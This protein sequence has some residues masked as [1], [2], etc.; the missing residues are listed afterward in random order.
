MLGQASSNLRNLGRLH[1]AAEPM[2][3][4]LERRVATEHWHNAAIVAANLSE[5][6]LMLGNT[7]AAV[8]AAARS[9]EYA[10]RGEDEF[11]RM[12]RRATLAHAQHQAGEE[13]RAR[14]LFEEAEAMQ[15]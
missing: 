5:L 14:E 13:A 2:R 8:E 4:G 10:D 7:S 3:A 15:G 12:T 1:E 6:E 9:M 11:M